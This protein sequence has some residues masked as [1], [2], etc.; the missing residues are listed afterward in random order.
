MGALFITV[1]LTQATQ[2]PLV[3]ADSPTTPLP[4]PPVTV[5]ANPVDAGVRE[6]STPPVFTSDVPV[7]VPVAAPPPKETPSEPERTAILH[8]S[9]LSLFATHLSFEL[10]KAVSKTVTV[11]GALGASLIP[12]VGFDLGLRVY[13]GDHLLEGPFLAVQGS[14]FWFSPASTLLVGPGAMF[15]YVFRPKGALTLSIGAGLQVWNQPTPDT[16]VRVLGIQPQT[17]VMLL[18]GFQRPGMGVWG[19]QPMLRFTVGPA[20]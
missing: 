5:I 9:P 19:P 13:V 16:S 18:P 8:F 2:P 3:N 1:L 7:D 11:F 4:P 12:Q 20:F 10:E 14:V 15:G 17:S 6:L